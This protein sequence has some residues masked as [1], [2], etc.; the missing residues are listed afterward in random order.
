MSES[1]PA[2]RRSDATKA[3]ILAAAREQFAA[4]GFQGATI[5][6]IASA[7]GIDP[8]MVMRY[9]GNKEALFAVAAEFDL[10]LPDLGALP[11]A[12]VGA[13]L[14][15]HF[16]DRWEG[17]EALL[18]LLRTA[19]TN[20]AASARIQAI[21]AGQM[22]PLIGRL[23]GE[24]RAAAAARAGLIA[25]Q[26]LGLAL[27]RYVLELPPVVRLKRAEIV[28]LVGPTIQAYLFGPGAAGS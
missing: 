9:F 22:A 10:R 13:A 6:G 2:P 11:R 16:L 21:F 28:R 19:A 4:G 25:T 18:A 12:E 17:D 8:A 14:V 15:A 26:I 23:S 3:A 1:S 7:A 5:R 27:C 20:A 24:P